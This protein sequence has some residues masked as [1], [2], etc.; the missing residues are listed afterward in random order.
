M[1][2]KM[3]QKRGG[4]SHERIINLKKL[5]ANIIAGNKVNKYSRNYH[6]ILED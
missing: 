2:I 1:R 3:K 6:L 5:N 4:T